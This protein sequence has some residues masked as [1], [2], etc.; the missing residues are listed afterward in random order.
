MKQTLITLWLGVALAIIPLS[1][2]AAGTAQAQLSNNSVRMYPGDCSCGFGLIWT[3]SFSSF[4][5]EDPTQANGEIAP[6]NPP[7]TRTHRTYLVLEDPSMF[8]SASYAELDLPTADANGNGTPDFF[9]V[10]QG[11]SAA[12]SGT[13][14]VIWGPGYGQL[15]F[16]WTRAAG[17]PQGSCLLTMIDPILGQMGPFTHAF[18]LTGY[19]GEMVYSPGSNSVTGTISFER[20]GPA[21]DVLEG[22]ISLVKVP[23]NRFNLLTLA[24][25][26]WTHQTD[27]FTFG[28][29][30]LT[31]D[32][33]RPTIYSGTLQNVV[34]AYGSW[35]WSIVD[36]NDANGNG[37]PDFSDDV[38]VVAPPRRPVLSLSSAQ[39]H[40]L[41]RVS[42]DVGHTHLVQEAASPNSTTWTTVQS[43]TLT[44]DPQVLTLPLPASSPTFWRVK[45]Q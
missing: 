12:S 35:K 16:Q 21:S 10:S 24:G 34:G 41:L 29:C 18:E 45:A 25:G 30:Q 3:M 13:Y 4:F 31:R 8:A 5:T 22:A 20:D 2:R 26:N 42:G 37:I 15:T 32:P 11:I 36:T 1:A 23:T 33:V 6:L 17:S 14:A 38:A 19:T 7:A 40:L 28:D 9:E 39:T 27:V 43:L 44:N